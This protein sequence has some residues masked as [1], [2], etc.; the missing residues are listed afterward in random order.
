[1]SQVLRPPGSPPDARDIAAEVVQS[2]FTVWNYVLVILRELCFTDPDL[3]ERLATQEF[4]LFLITLMS[5][6]QVFDHAVGLVEEILAVRSSTFYLGDIPRLH[7]LLSK[8]CSQQLVLFSRVLA[9]LV[10]EPE[11][12]QLMESTHMLRSMELLQLRRDRVVRADSVIDRNQAIVLSAPNL[13]PRLVDLLRTMNYCP[14]L[15]CGVQAMGMED[16]GVAVPAMNLGFR[17]TAGE[18]TVGR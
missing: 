4:I 14:P 10:F 13:L 3:S 16:G 15:D 8:L 17:V 2:H 6:P 9:L 1:M 18:A 11:Y 12:R 5:H 7:S